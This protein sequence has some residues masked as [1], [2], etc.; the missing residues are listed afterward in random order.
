MT[1]LN[2]H[3]RMNNG[4]PEKWE[5]DGSPMSVNT[6][7]H[8]EANSDHGHIKVARIHHGSKTEREIDYQANLIKNAPETLYKLQEVIKILKIIP[9]YTEDQYIVDVINHAIKD[10]G[11]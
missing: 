8:T 5:I 9:E 2:F 10:F 1:L 6:W 11:W 4:K 7:I 3:K